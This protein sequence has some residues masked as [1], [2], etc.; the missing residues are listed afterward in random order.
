MNREAYD[1][2]HILGQVSHEELAHYYKA[3]K[4]HALISWMDTPGLSSLEAG[5]MGCN[6]VITDKGDTRDY[7]GD[8]A[9]YYEP[10]SIDSIRDAIVRAYNA[11]VDPA[12]S[13]LIREGYNWQKTAEKTL[14]RYKHALV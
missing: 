14:E 13:R 9:F 1:R 4:V 8:D 11:P 10:D 7:F 2:V 6:L 3:A 12:L 5:A